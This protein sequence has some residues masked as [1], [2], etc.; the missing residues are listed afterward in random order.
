MFDLMAEVEA[1]RRQKKDSTPVQGL[2][3]PVQK[4]RMLNLTSIIRKV[5]Q[6]C[7]A[8]AQSLNL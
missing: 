2:C 5:A 8:C 1:F 6:A 3:K 7:T 4:R